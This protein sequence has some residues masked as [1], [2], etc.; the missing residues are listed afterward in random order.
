MWVQLDV[1]VGSTKARGLKIQF[2]VEKLIM[3]PWVVSGS[4]R[5]G[6]NMFAL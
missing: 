5:A 4:T 6:Q 2:K 3:E 1:Q